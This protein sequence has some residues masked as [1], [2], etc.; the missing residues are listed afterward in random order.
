MSEHNHEL[1]A[2]H[3]AQPLPARLH[4]DRPGH[5]APLQQ[6]AADPGGH[7]HPRVLGARGNDA[8]AAGPLRGAHPQSLRLLPAPHQVR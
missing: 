4:Q 3:A 5:P 2:R 8:R 7:A 1:H 6:G